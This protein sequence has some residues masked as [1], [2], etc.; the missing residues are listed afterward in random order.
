MIPPGG[1]KPGLGFSDSG[2]QGLEVPGQGRED[3]RGGFQFLFF[4]LDMGNGHGEG[5][6]V[7][8]GEIPEFAQPNQDGFPLFHILQPAPDVGQPSGNEGDIPVEL[9][10]L[11]RQGRDFVLIAPSQNI[12]APVF[13]TVAVVFFVTPAA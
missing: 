2:F 7:Q 12:P 8:I 13:Q 11:G 4:G 1:V 3:A 9:A 10:G 6:P 5:R